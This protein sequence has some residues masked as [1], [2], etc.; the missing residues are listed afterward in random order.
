MEENIAP[1][2]IY[3]NVKNEEHNTVRIVCNIS[4]PFNHSK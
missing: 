2:E 1:E 4:T 3:E